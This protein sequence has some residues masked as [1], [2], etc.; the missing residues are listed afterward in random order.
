MSFIFSMSDA[1]G[2]L[3]QLITITTRSVTTIDF[4]EQETEDSF[5][6]LAVVQKAKPEDIDVDKFDISRGYITVHTERE[7]AIGV[8]VEWSN[9]QY[10]T[11]S[12]SDNRDYGFFKRIAEEVK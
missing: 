10:R 8:D 5:S 7:L 11:I 12:F 1:F 6:I 9:R 2:D 3:L 4:V